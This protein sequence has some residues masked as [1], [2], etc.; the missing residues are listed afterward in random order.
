MTGASQFMING[1]GLE[2]GYNTAKDKG[3]QHEIRGRCAIF[4]LI[5]SDVASDVSGTSCL[6]NFINRFMESSP[7]NRHKKI[8]SEARAI[9]HM[10]TT[11]SPLNRRS[12]HRMMKSEINL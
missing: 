1:Q 6:N 8:T 9:I 3:K 7:I 12:C 10:P 2:L 5:C 4:K 11:S